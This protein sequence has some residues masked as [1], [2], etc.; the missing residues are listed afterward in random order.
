M[1]L[2]GFESFRNSELSNT[3]RSKLLGFD[4]DKTAAMHKM[5]A[6]RLKLNRQR[7]FSYYDLS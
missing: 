5:V 1:D 3:I 7:L 6:G 2:L 4:H